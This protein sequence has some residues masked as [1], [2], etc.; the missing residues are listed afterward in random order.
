LT[1][2]LNHPLEFYYQNLWSYYHASGSDF[3]AIGPLKCGPLDRACLSLNVGGSGSLDLFFDQNF[4]GW[5]S[6]YK[7]FGG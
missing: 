7:I 1:A 2:I 3:S 5:T 6:P 4:L